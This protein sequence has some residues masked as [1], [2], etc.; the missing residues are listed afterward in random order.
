MQ[1]DAVAV[2]ALIPMLG[3]VALI[4]GV[5]RQFDR[6]GSLLAYSVDSAGWHWLSVSVVSALFGAF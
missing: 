6:L 2:Q 1:V 5:R 4:S 3:W